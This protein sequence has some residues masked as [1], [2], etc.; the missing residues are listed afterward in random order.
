MHSLVKNLPFSAQLKSQLQLATLEDHCLQ[1][2][3]QLSKVGWPSDRRRAPEEVRPRWNVRDQVYEAEGLMFLG[4]KLIVPP[5][6]RK[7][8]LNLVHESH[9]GIEKSKARAREVMYWPGMTRDIENKVNRCRKWVEWRRNT[10]KEPLIHHEVPIRPWQKLGADLVEFRGQSYLCVVDYFSKF[11]EISR[12]QIKTASSIITHLKSIFARHGVP[13][14]LV[15]DNT[16]FASRE[17]QDFASLWGF[18][19][20]TS[21]PRYPQSNGMSERAIGTIKQLLRKAEDPYIALLEYRNTPV[22]GIGLSPSQMLNRR[23]LKSKLP[24]TAK[25]LRPRVELDAREKLLGA[26]ERQK[27]Y[28]GRHAK[29]LKGLELEEMAPGRLQWSLIYG[30]PL[31]RTW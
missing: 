7:D 10:Q 28:Y 4:E 23:R 15:A 20:T 30:L 17:L 9:Q 8:M 21:S 2:L 22:S 13:D 3:Q 29:P 1:L 26:Q 5:R 25:L 24:T 16:P 6:L 12:L 18:R 19:I 14:E 11:P 31:D 27:F